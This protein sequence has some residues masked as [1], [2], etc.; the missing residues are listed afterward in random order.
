MT[1]RE[2]R[3]SALQPWLALLDTCLQHQQAA[4]A[5]NPA[6]LSALGRAQRVLQAMALDDEAPV[7][8]WVQATEHAFDPD[9]SVRDLRPARLLREMRSDRDAV[10][11]LGIWGALHALLRDTGSAPGSAGFAALMAAVSRHPDAAA[12]SLQPGTGRAGFAGSG[13]AAEF[14][15][16]RLKRTLANL[17]ALYDGQGADF[18]RWLQLPDYAPADATNLRRWAQAWT[19]AAVATYVDW[20]NRASGGSLA[21]ALHLIWG[22][23]PKRFRPAARVVQ[24][25][26][27]GD[28]AQPR[29]AVLP[30][31]HKRMHFELLLPV[32]L[33]QLLDNQSGR[34][35]A[36][37]AGARRF[38]VA[39][40]MKALDQADTRRRDAALDDY[41]HFTTY[42]GLTILQIYMAAATDRLCRLQPLA[43]RES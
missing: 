15:N 20:L 16:A 41:R 31:D 6:A 35:V 2:D 23:Q 7:P 14:F 8:A 38:V 9:G 36:W 42:R 27:G 19:V 28:P 30:T 32:V 37:R 3:T 43:L 11:Q 34:W 22:D 33:A 13:A 29:P 40:S 24:A 5:A 25:A 1:V 39:L 10:L 4:A 12:P 18:A 26:T 21:A 17:A